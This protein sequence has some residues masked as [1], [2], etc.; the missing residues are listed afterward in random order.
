MCAACVRLGLPTHPPTH[1][2]VELQA[3]FLWRTA[4]KSLVVREIHQTINAAVLHCHASDCCLPRRDLAVRWGILATFRIR[5]RPARPF[6]EREDSAPTWCRYSSRRAVPPRPGRPAGPV[7][8]SVADVAE[9]DMERG[10]VLLPPSCAAPPCSP[11]HV[12]FRST[13][14]C[15][16]D[17]HVHRVPHSRR[18]SR[19]ELCAC[20]GSLRCP[21]A[22]LQSS[23]RCSHRARSARMVKIAVK[24]SG[25]TWR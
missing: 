16:F 12:V 23:L 20:P 7:G 22:D 13:R 15:V 6:M 3:S 8:E 2:G 10:N 9:V 24:F 4:P 25:R 1:L 21:R 17:S 5:W 19:P 18:S 14:D 11:S